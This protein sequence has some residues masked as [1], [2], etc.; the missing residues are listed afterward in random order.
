MA[1]NWQ[2]PDFLES[3]SVFFQGALVG[4]GLRE[5][6]WE[7]TMFGGALEKDTPI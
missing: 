2:G 1:K 5:T 6:K 3:G 4:A 7:P